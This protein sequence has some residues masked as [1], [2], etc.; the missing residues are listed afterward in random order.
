MSATKVICA[1]KKVKSK[2]QSGTM[3]KL[4]MTE[5]WDVT[6]SSSYQLYNSGWVLACSTIFFQASLSSIL[7]FQFIIFIARRSASTS[8]FH[9]VT[10]Y[11]TQKP[12]FWTLDL[13]PSLGG[14]T[15]GN[16]LLKQVR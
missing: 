2:I 13:P 3:V 9:D 6:H 8:S 5:I 1:Y 7:V 15:K 14:M 4:V 12:T 10:H 16:N 11:P